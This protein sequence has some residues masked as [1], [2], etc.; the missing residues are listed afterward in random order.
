MTE[1]FHS[2]WLNKEY[3]LDKLSITWLWVL[4]TNYQRN[5]A[6][7]PSYNLPKIKIKIKPRSTYPKT[8]NSGARLRNGKVLGT[9]FTQ[10][11]SGLLDSHNQCTPLCMLWMICCTCETKIKSHKFINEFILFFIKNSHMFC[12]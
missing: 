1:L 8:L 4:I 5:M 7:C 6:F 11:E 9:H 12:D 2:H 3:K 10:T